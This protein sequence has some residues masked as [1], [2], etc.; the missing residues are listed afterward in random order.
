MNLEPKILI[1]FSGLPGVGKTTLAQRLAQDAKAAYLRIDTIEQALKNSALGIHQ[2]EDAGYQSA[3]SLAEENLR[4]GNS[5]IVDAVNPL[6]IIRDRWAQ[7]A[8]E[9]EAKL[10]NIEVICSDKAE[11]KRRIETREA[12]IKGHQLPAWEE[13]LGR[14]Y[15][16][17]QAWRVTLDTAS[18]DIKAAHKALLKQIN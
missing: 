8:S 16:T 3:Y 6:N 9:T 4:A 10:I 18:L 12:D 5:V 14:E 15:E 1:V 7:I 13:V 11:H 2:A 17:W